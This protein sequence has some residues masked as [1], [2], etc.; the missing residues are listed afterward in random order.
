MAD[1]LVCKDCFQSYP[2]QGEAEAQ[3]VTDLIKKV[4]KDLL[5]ELMGST[6][7][8]QAATSGQ[9]ET[10]DV[11]LPGP[12]ATCPIIPSSLPLPTSAGDKDGSED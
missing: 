8:Q 6:P 12:S 4:V 3:Q 5:V 1:K 9:D 7:S 10:A 11:V 2:T